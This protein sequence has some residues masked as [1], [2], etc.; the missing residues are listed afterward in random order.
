MDSLRRLRCRQFG[1]AT[2]FTVTVKRFVS[3][4][5]YL[6]PVETTGALPLKTRRMAEVSGITE[7][8][9]LQAEI[10]IL[11]KQAA[12][13]KKAENTSAACPRIVEAVTSKESR[14]G[15]IMKAGAENDQNQFHAPVGASSGGG[16]CV[17]Q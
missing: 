15:F 5:L 4:G 17:V 2:P 6:I 7:L 1:A 3:S 14:D 12:G 16:C 13:I 9:I 10:D 11:E 8:Q